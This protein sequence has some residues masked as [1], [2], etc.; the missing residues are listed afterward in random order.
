VR[1]G[2]VGRRVEKGWGWAR[3]K[4]NQGRTKANAVSKYSRVR[5]A[6][7]MWNSN[8]CYCGLKRSNRIREYL[9]MRGAVE[10]G[11]LWNAGCYGYVEFK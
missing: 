6:V 11:V 3:V 4:G 5:G 7:D 2:G 1:C 10:C 8:E 9:L